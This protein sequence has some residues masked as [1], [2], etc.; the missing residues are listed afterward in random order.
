L[1]RLKHDQRTPSSFFNTI[2][3]LFAT[4]YLSLRSVDLPLSNIP[5]IPSPLSAF[6][7]AELPHLE[8]IQ[9]SCWSNSGVP[10][11]VTTGL[12]LLNALAAFPNVQKLIFAASVPDISAPVAGLARVLGLETFLMA[13]GEA[14]SDWSTHGVRKLEPNLLKPS[15]EDGKRT[16]LGFDLEI[17]DEHTEK[18]IQ[19]QDGFLRLLGEAFPLLENLRSWESSLWSVRQQPLAF[20]GLF[21]GL[22]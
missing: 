18:R 14:W 7:A 6:L 5:H 12:W 13:R 1:I 16:L 9:L 20:P 2:S 3:F 21:D 11:E 15:E 4:F 19:L 10:S 17:W 8:E 22:C